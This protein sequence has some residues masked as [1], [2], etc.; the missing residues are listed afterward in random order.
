MIGFLWRLFGVIK[1]DLPKG[2]KL[3]QVKT[4]CNQTAV[5][6][7][8][9]SY[10]GSTAWCDLGRISVVVLDRPFFGQYGSAQNYEVKRYEKRFFWSG[11][12]AVIKISAP[13]IS[14]SIIMMLIDEVQR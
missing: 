3:L 8:F 1:Y 9:E 13:E 4:L 6:A 12:K 11:R 10:A 5:A 14:Q 7:G 2:G